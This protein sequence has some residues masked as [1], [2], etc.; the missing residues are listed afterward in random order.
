MPEE[1]NLLP[2]LWPLAPSGVTDWLLDLCGDGV[3]GFMPPAMPD[4]AWV[5]NAMYEHEQ[6]LAEVS[7]HEFRQVQLADGSVQPH[8][9][10]GI[11]L[12]A[13]GVS[14][15][16]NWVAPSTPVAAGGGCAGRNSP[17][18]WATLSCPKGFCLLTVASLQPRRRGAGRSASSRR[19]KGA[20]TARPGAD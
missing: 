17:G 14:R 7:Y 19:P 5:L 9:V 3:T 10:A 16:A 18:E 1:S 8:I 6:G 20:W 4:A 12:E 15:E 2:G 13:V 11:D